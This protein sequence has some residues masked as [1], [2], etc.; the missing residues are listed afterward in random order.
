MTE[1]HRTAII[2]G[3]L[4]RPT[5]LA[6]SGGVLDNNATFF[7]YGCGRAEDI[8]GLKKLGFSARGWD[9]NHLPD[10]P[11]TNSDVV[12]LGYVINVIED[13]QER[14]AA[15]KEAWNLTSKA[16][17]VSARLMSEERAVT[18]GQVRGDGYITGHDT[19]QKFYTQSELRGWIDSNLQVESIAAAPGVFIIFRNEEDANEY[20]IKNRRRRFF[21]VKI[22]R[23]DL[24]YE[25]HQEPLDELIEWFTRRGRLPRKGENLELERDLKSAVGGVKR[26]WNVIH[27]VTEDTDWEE[28][29]SSR[30]DDLLVDLALLKLNR[31]PNFM[32]LPETTRHDIKDFFGSYKQATLEA[33]Q[34]LFS[35]GNFELIEKAANSLDIGKRL[36]TA[37]YVHISALE[38]L[39]PVLRVYEGCARWLIGE[40]DNANIIKLATHKPKVSYLT[41]P[42]FDKDPHP[43]LQEALFVR[44]RDLD[45]DGRDYN[46]S[47]NPPI[48]HR[49]ETFVTNDYHLYEKFARLTKQEEKFGLFDEDARLIGNREGWNERVALLGLE[50]RGHRVVKSSNMKDATKR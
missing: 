2:R 21:P 1:S 36:P 35:A 24:I 15:L 13:Q 40:V 33:D 47:T 28:I 44:I 22:S 50:I 43:A 20:I 38:H 17:V 14:V 39:P 23:A 26:A 29:S 10:E 34:L 4:S 31:R 5:R 27:K 8:V 7:D 6:I 49:K 3:E 37:L 41:Y 16:L 32:A 45:V 46:N 18:R 11:K 30:R 25:K 12:N 48:L 42:K 19:F 9:P